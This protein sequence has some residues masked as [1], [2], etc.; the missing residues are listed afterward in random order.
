VS[1]VD[2]LTVPVRADAPA[3]PVA[4]TYWRALLELTKPGITRMVLVTT[5]AGFYLASPGSVDWPLLA[6]TLVATALVA[7]ASGALNQWAEREADGRMVRTRRRPLPSGRLARTQALVFATLLGLA[8]L[9][10]MA[11]WVGPVPALLVGASLLTYVLVYTPLKRLTWWATIVGAFPGAL[12]ILAGWTA[13]GGG[14]DA[15][16]LVLF[17]ILFLWQMP[18]FYALAWIYR[19]DYLRGGFRLLSADDPTG[20]RTARQAVLFAVLLLP[21]SLLPGVVGGSGVAYVAGAL[22]LGFVYVGLGVGLLMHRSSRRAWRLF[23]ASVV[24]LPALLLLM[25]LDKAAV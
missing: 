8:G 3:A 20:I 11:L 17:G 25:V 14:I 2:Q 4:G 24:Y 7:S 22:A 16:G 15:A 18:H 5:A 21:V 13:A 19:D 10:V 9:L 23:F 1:T 12:P 6:M